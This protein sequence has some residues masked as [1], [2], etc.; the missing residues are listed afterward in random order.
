M[1]FLFAINIV[2]ACAL[3]FWPAWFARVQLRLPWANPF[4]ILLAIA[5]PVQVMKLFGGP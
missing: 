4:T 1:D 5:L 2:A 3:L